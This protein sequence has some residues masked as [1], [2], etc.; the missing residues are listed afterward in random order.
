[1]KTFVTLMLV[2]CMGLSGLGPNFSEQHDA[3]PGDDAADDGT[4]SWV[5]RAEDWPM[6]M[7]DLNHTGNTSSRIPNTN[8]SLWNFSTGSAI[9]SSPAIVGGVVYIGSNDNNLY[10]IWA[11]NGTQKWSFNDNG[12]LDDVPGSPTVVNGKVYFNAF[13]AGV[14]CLWASNGTKIWNTTIAP[15]INHRNYSSATVVGDSVYIADDGIPATIFALDADDGHERWNHP[16]S[17]GYIVTTAAYNNGKL[18]F[19]AQSGGGILC[20]WASNG[21][22]FWKRNYQGGG[23]YSAPSIK[24]DKLFFTTEGSPVQGSRIYAIDKDDGSQIWMNTTP[25]Q[26]YSSPA[27][28]ED[29]VLIA[30]HA[31]WQSNGTRVWANGYSLYSTP[32]VSGDRMVYLNETDLRCQSIV[33]GTVIW[34]VYVNGEYGSPAVVENMV[35]V[36]GKDG[37]VRAFSTPDVT[38]PNVTGNYPADAA[39]DVD[40]AASISVEFSELMNEAVTEAAFSV[41]PSVTGQFTWTGTNMTFDPTTQLMDETTYTVTVNGAATDRS[42][43]GLDGDMDG[44]SEGSP[45][46]DFT[47]SFTTVAGPPPTVMSVTPIDGA[48]RIAITANVIVQFSD[49]MD[50]ATTEGA[51]DID[52]PVAGAFNWNGASTIMTYNPTAVFPTEVTYNCTVAHTA[53]SQ[54]G[55]ELDGNGDGTASGDTTDDFLWSFSVNDTF[56]PQ[57]IDFDPVDG[58]TEVLIDD[59]ITL[60]FSEAMDWPTVED[61]F[62]LD[63]TTDGDMTWAGD[64]LTFTAN[65]TLYPGTLYTVTIQTSALDVVGNP[66]D[67]DGDGVGGEMSDRVRFSF[68]TG[69]NASNPPPAVIST[70]PA[71]READVALDT[72]LVVEFNTAMDK[73]STESAFALLGVNPAFLSFEWDTDGKVMTVSVASDLDGETNYTAKVESTAMSLLGLRLDGNRNGYA[74]WSAVDDYTWT[75]RTGPVPVTHPLPRVDHVQPAPGSTGVAL[76]TD[77]VIVFTEEMDK[78]VTEDAIMLGSLSSVE[79]VLTWSSDGKTATIDPVNDL[80]QNTTYSLKVTG[81]AMSAMGKALDGNA[82]GI[83]EGLGVD[84]HTWEFRTETIVVIKHRPVAA[85]TAPADGAKV[86]G[87][88]GIE[89]TASDD[90]TF[91]DLVASQVRFDQGTWLSVGTGSAW[92]YTWDTKQTENGQHQISVRA[93]DG[94]L[95]SDVITITVEVDNKKAEPGSGGLEAYLLPIII[96][97]IIVVVLV[98]AV[99]LMRRRGE[100]PAEPRPAWQQTTGTSQPDLMG[101]QATTQ[102]PPQQP[103]QGSPQQPPVQPTPPQEPQPPPKPSPPAREEGIREG[104]PQTPPPPGA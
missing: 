5:S 23:V 34:E 6:F 13:N 95:Y 49:P 76:D 68:T 17:S 62:D 75:F 93:F 51:F 82:N 58:A 44:T 22:E 33:D 61:A 38:P 45:T 48:I 67:Q 4:W 63:P 26:T 20:L 18:Y 41:S 64:I 71:P 43:N 53:M 39:V 3:G 7:H 40:L 8:Q 72:Q 83:A 32:A 28:S 9:W 10:A 88:V 36:G 1:M 102:P 60:T 27:L 11:N 90:D 86:K 80:V 101:Q 50:H 2:L 42:G 19:G 96:V 16:V 79:Y 37:V 47:F 30:G 29:K 97:I 91:I 66:L 55:K 78:D 57:V 98:V 69:F 21:T 24:D 94:E 25:G 87:V 46:D 74:E 65:G 35:V 99:V 103:P 31:F 89:G 84:D 15:V 56:P 70:T 54:S 92:V 52:P 59:V 77:I 12:N 104:P 100:G 85:I 81:D 73:A 14:Y